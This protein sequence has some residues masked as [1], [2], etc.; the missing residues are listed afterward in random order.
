MKTYYIC[1]AIVSFLVACGTP[2]VATKVV[3]KNL[4]VQGPTGKVIIFPV[5]NFKGERS[6]ST[7]TYDPVVSKAWGQ[8]YGKDNIINGGDEALKTV[9][10][11]G[12]KNY[13]DMINS[14]NKKSKISGV[15]KNEWVQK[16]ALKVTEKYGPHSIGFAIANGGKVRFKDGKPVYLHLAVFDTQHMTWKWVTKVRGNGDNWNST[17]SNMVKYG[18]K[19]LDGL[20]RSR[21]GEAASNRAPASLK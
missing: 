18:F 20:E 8:V 2:Q 12:R 4:Q 3:H 21:K 11:L 5:T 9:R 19:E 13:R 10:E 17:T 1:L 14:I 6:E 15:G 16:M 7:K